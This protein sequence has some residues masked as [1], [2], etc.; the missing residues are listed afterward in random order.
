[1]QEKFSLEESATMNAVITALLVLFPIFRDA[2]GAG[3]NVCPTYKDYET[4]NT[5]PKCWYDFAADSTAVSLKKLVKTFA[6]CA[7][8]S[9]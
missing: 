5:N 9:I 7:V 8:E 3:N 4:I 6:I 1:M 2:Y